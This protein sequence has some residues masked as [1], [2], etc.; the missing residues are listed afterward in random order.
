M[1][2]KKPS[3]YIYVNKQMH[4]FINIGWQAFE[5]SKAIPSNMFTKLTFSSITS[6]KYNRQRKHLLENFPSNNL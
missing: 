5:V 3:I 2:I 4:Q 6:E 1:I